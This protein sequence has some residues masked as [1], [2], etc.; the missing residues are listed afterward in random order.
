M[1]IIISPS[2]YNTSRAERHAWKIVFSGQERLQQVNMLAAQ[3]ST[4]TE[5]AFLLA[6][7]DKWSLCWAHFLTKQ[8]QKDS[9]GTQLCAFLWVDCR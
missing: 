3:I 9:G 1:I 6:G 8:L 2:D 4:V 5:R 7:R